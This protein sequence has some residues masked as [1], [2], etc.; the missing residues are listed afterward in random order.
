[1]SGPGQ[2][3][4]LPWSNEDL[5]RIH[6]KHN[7][8]RPWPT[9]F[10]RSRCLSP[11]GPGTPPSAL[12][13][14][15]TLPDPSGGS[16]PGG[17]VRKPRF[18]TKLPGTGGRVQVSQ[19]QGQGHPGEVGQQQAQQQA[20]QA[21]QP[22]PHPQQLLQQQQPQQQLQQAVLLQVRCVPAMT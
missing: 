12:P 9:S 16:Q 8:W 15:G 17:A 3:I 18:K 10:S 22:Q 19:P 7:M 4:S 13:A 11:L 6:L 21:L 5:D 14:G 1:M 20:Q 2:Q